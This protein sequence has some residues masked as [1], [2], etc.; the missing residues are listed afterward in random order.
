MGVRI[1]PPTK[2]PTGSQARHLPRPAGGGHHAASF[3][4]L[5][6]PIIAWH[7]SVLYDADE[8]VRVGCKTGASKQ[9]TAIQQK[10]V[11]EWLNEK[12]ADGPKMVT[13]ID[14]QAL[15]DEVPPALLKRAKI[16]LGVV[17]TGANGYTTWSLPTGDADETE[18]EVLDELLDGLFEPELKSSAEK[19]QSTNRFKDADQLKDVDR[20]EEHNR[21]D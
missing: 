21:T 20:P 19:R 17:P 6:T 10:K 14:R 3:D 9:R 18:D 16:S 12:L 15:L 11:E 1:G 13:E 5:A 2:T 8:L 4:H 7:G